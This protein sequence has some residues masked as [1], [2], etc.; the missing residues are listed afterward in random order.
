MRWSG[1]FLFFNRFPII[2]LRSVDSLNR[3]SDVTI[4]DAT[5]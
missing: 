5:G 3:L 1:F 4:H 2:L